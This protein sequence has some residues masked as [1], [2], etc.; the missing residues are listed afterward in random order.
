MTSLVPLFLL[1][2]STVSDPLLDR[3]IEESLAMR[4][5]LR[6]AEATLRA[7][8]E[9][10][11]P[12]GALP[13]PSFDVGF[14]NE[15]FGAI[16]LGEA[17]DT[18]FIVMG[19]Q[20]FPWFPKLDLRSDIA[21]AEAKQQVVRIERVRLGIEAE[22]RRA[23]L[24]LLLARDRSRLLDR[25]DALWSES[26]GVARVRYE[27]GEAPQSDVLRA[28][29]ELNRLR[30]RRWAREAEEQSSVQA[31]N[32]LRGRPLDESIETSTSLRKI[33]APSLPPFEEAAADAEARSPELRIAALAIESAE[34]AVDLAE[35]E[36]VPDF[37]IRA[38]VMPRAKELEPMWQVGLTFT[39]PIY[40][41]SKQN[42]AVAENE[43]RREA[44][45]LDRRALAELVRLRVKQR[46]TALQYLRRTIE[47]YRDGL[48]I[49]SDATAESTLSQYQ[50]GRVSFASVLEAF[51]GY[52]SDEE[53]YLTA[54]GDAQRIAIAA[55]EVS[56]D[57]P[58]LGGAPMRAGAPVAAEERREE[59][60]PMGGM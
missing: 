48:L 34:R 25:L 16:T 52:V 31:L 54:L 30:R 5:E 27:A 50:V 45:G 10:I 3:L 26:A 19:T 60:R 2:S 20:V 7:E 9:R 18:F 56:L 11:A 1:A 53:D 49:Q 29:L 39:L 46:E 28:Q 21:S 24:D 57:E 32:R 42:R 35:W 12:A 43:A 36:R 47:L 40:F 44:S 37:G 8:R 15:S 41:W 59:A 38:G 13:D 58:T 22:V 33:G 4:P 51:V 17:E 55:L 6:A 23:Y 14:Q